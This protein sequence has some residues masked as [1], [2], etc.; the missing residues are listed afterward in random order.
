MVQ[1]GQLRDKLVS[2]IYIILKKKIFRSL[3]ISKVKDNKDSK[4]S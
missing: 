4:S 3:E 2:Q 1:V